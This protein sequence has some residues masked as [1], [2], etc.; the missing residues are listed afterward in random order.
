MHTRSGAG[1]VNYLCDTTEVR[2]RQLAAGGAQT[3]KQKAGQSKDVDERYKCSASL[4]VCAC[5]CS[6]V[7]TTGGV[8]TSNP[9]AARQR[10]PAGSSRFFV[11]EQ[12]GLRVPQK[13]RDGLAARLNTC[14]H[15]RR[16]RCTRST[17]SVD[18]GG[19]AVSRMSAVVKEEVRGE[20]TQAETRWNAR[21]HMSQ[22]LSLSCA[23]DLCQRAG[24]ATWVGWS[25]QV[26][27]CVGE[28]V[29]C[30]CRDRCATV[31]V[32]CCGG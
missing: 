31:R 6:Q 30:V 18:E 5:A 8:R 9:R 25:P 14:I 26:R 29:R 10:W 21:S 28:K 24:V 2:T 7:A 13:R 11:F 32:C 1:P 3:R 17:V 22:S 23:L 20:K 16:G 4:S 19:F 27:N 15:K 12:T